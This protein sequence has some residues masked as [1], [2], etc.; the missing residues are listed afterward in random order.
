M[1]TFILFY[2]RDF[3]HKTKY[4][5]AYLKACKWIAKNIMSKQVE[6]GETYWK[7]EKVAD[8]D[9]PT[10]HLELYAALDTK[11]TERI[12]CD[13]C[14]DFH[15][16]F[17]INEEYNCNSCKMKAFKKQHESKLKTKQQYRKERLNIVLDK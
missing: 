11:D 12:F 9:C 16:K 2:E 8:T 7:I 3:V 1:Q 17:Y 10:C 14:K 5:A 6:I 13:A 15:C 4:K